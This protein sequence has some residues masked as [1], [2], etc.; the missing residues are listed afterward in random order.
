M[1]RSNTSEKSTMES[2]TQVTYGPWGLIAMFVAGAGVAATVAL[3]AARKGGDRVTKQTESVLDACAEAISKLEQ[4]L[5]R[6]S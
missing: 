6:A 1:S 5:M 4:R 3:L 2:E